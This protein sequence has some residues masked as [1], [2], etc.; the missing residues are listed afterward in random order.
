MHTDLREIIRCP[1]CHARLV[2]AAPE[3][4]ECSEC[5]AVYPVYD[6]TPWLYRDVAGSRAQWA[7][8]LQQFRT[9]LLEDHV[10]LEAAG[11]AE[12]LLPATR[13]RLARQKAGLV[14]LGEQVFGLLEC[15]ALAHSEAG[16]ALPRER[17]P[18][19]Q[20]V[21]SY[22]ETVFRDWCWGDEEVRETLAMLEPLLGTSG[23][24]ARALVLGGGGGRLSFELARRGKYSSVVQLD[25][26]PLLTRIGQ[27]VA[28]GETIELTEIPRF[29]LGLEHVA[30]GQRLRAPAASDVAAS[31]LHFLLGDA[32]ASPFA[33]ESFDLLLTPWFID[34]L[35]ES[36]RRVARRLGGLLVTGGRWISFGPLSFESVGPEDRLTPEEM[37]EAL[38]EAGF[39]VEHVALERVSYL[40]TPHGM[41]RRG[42]EIFVFSATLRE[43][44]PIEDDFAFYPEWMTDGTQAIPNSPAFEQM[45]AERTFDVEIL[46]CIDGRASI[47]DLVVTLSSRFGLEPDRCRNII[48]RFFTRSVDGS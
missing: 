29:P 13:D 14:R 38:E 5:E 18:S 16:G 34:I 48:N 11:H 10:E 46:K 36:F 45:R 12:G 1:A 26:N 7:A 6:G 2:A 24:G 44:P 8:K 47:E 27:R 17:I 23:E 33:R 32:L 30:V 9:E 40:H 41:A 39:E 35:P 19:Q 28:R 20:H 15:F 43:R 31:P 4:L 42:E 37:N 22:L 25:L 3:R 21:S